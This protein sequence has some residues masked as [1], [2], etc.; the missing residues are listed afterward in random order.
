MSEQAAR[1]ALSRMNMREVAVASHYTALASDL[2]MMAEA[3][4]DQAEASFLARRGEMCA[5][6]GF[7][8]QEQR[9]PFAFAAGLAIIPV[10]GTLVN[11]FGASWGYVTGYNFIRS[12][13]NLALADDDVKGIVLDMNSYGGEAAG[14]F[15]LS[16]DIRAA[17]EKKP[18]M[19]MVDSNCYSAGY[20]IASAASKIVAIP[21]AGVGSIGVI[22]MHVDQSK[23]L[24]A[25][26]LKIT[27]IYEAEHKAD[28]NPFE[29]LPDDVR[30]SMQASIHAS[31]EAFVS[32]VATNRGMDAQKV[33]D[34]K[35]RC[36][37]A[38]E[39]M[40]LGL[41]DAISSPTEAAMAFLDEL[42]GS[43]HQLRQGASMTTAAQNQ[44]GAGQQAAPA[45][46]TTTAPEA[47]ATEA[48]NAERARIQG[49]LNCEEA[50]GRETLAN[51]LAMETSM[52]ADDAKKLLAAAPKAEG[53]PAANNNGF[54]AAMNASQH[55]NV[56]A[57]T[58][59]AAEGANGAT[60]P[61]AQIL[62]DQAMATG[63]KQAK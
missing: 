3:K 8:Q 41:I 58:S 37:R 60:D 32:L 12:Q 1:A 21:S 44:P 10:S 25:W 14:C 63:S 49:I 18:V 36:Y 19:A 11:R 46:A 9:K 61:A 20:A 6:Y 53:K 7:N 28:G 40:A 27:L 2:R 24:D 26:G 17:R 4:A 45:T 5:A 56:G 50:K 52:S 34:T 39:A 31:Y 22:A 59:A 48:R 30:E 51:H 42:S 13:L 33:R 62:A 43:D 23:L 54:A 55:P 15:E 57:D 47:S 16:A 29:P 35:S 38:E